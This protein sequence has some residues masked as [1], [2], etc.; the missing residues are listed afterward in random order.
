MTTNSA[1]ARKKCTGIERNR[2]LTLLKHLRKS[3]LLRL[4][5]ALLLGEAIAWGYALLRDGATLK[6]KAEALRWLIGHR[7]EIRQRRATVQALRAIEDE[8]LVSLM[9]NQ[10]RFD[11]II[12]GP[13]GQWMNSLTE[14]LL[15]WWQRQ[16][17]SLFRV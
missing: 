15:G 14:P 2:H 12:K 7:N 4:L 5:P 13:V 9:T 16:V 3:T 17:I 8:V 6:A 11:Q 10:I 1:L